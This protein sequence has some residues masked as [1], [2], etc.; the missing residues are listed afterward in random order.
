MRLIEEP[1]WTPDGTLDFPFTYVYDASALTDAVNFQNIAVQ[2][3]G[4]SAFVLR[5]IMGVP[6]CVDTPANGGRFNFRNANGS[7]AAGNP[8]SGIILPNVFPIV[9]EKLYRVN[10][11][12][13]IDLYKVLRDHTTC[14][15]GTIYN[16]QIAFT[17]VKRFGK[18]SGYPKQVTPYRYRE[19]PFSYTFPLTINW[20]H[21]DV[22]G[23]AQPSQRFNVQMDNWDFEL[24]RVTISEQG[25]TGAL[26]G[27]DFRIMLYDPNL[28]AFSTAPLNQGFVNGARISPALAGA[29]QATFP[30]PTVLY[31]A[32]S[33]ITFDITSMLCASALPETY[34]IVFQGV[35]RINC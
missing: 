4:D 18:G 32:G 25:E 30:T 13:A 8:S 33:A 34:D 14:S 27:N 22:N 20:A 5:R 35:R 24:M 15:E 29:Y 10:D 23:N 9:P 12:I 11:Q 19:F 17:G 3:Q 28:H 2:L 16:S 6:L 26:A 1:Y 31:P 21:F 7:Y